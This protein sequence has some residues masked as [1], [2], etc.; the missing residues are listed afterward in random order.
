[1]KKDIEKIT[2]WLKDYSNDVGSKGYVIGLSGGV[3]STAACGL[4][5]DAV[6]KEN[7]LGIMLPFSTDNWLRSPSGDDLK[8]GIRVAEHYGIKYYV[9]PISYGEIII[10]N[11]KQLFDN[12]F[13]NLYHN[14]IKNND[15]CKGNIQARLRM[16]ALRMFAE[17]MNYLVL[18]TTNKSED[19][20]GYFKKGGDGGSGV[21]VEPMSDFYKSEIIKMVEYYGLP[22]DLV[23]R[24]PSAGL[25]K[26]QTDEGEL[27]FTYVDFEKYWKWKENK[28]GDCPVSDEISKEIER[29][30][31]I[32]EHKRSVPSKYNRHDI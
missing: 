23:N 5:V 26:G 28:D 7:V 14:K 27:G 20:L 21:D 6:G 32:T 8:D 22:E 19:M 15:L 16:I 3:D 9:Y 25:W 29:R 24:T 10:P 18:G 11:M 17:A 1:M 31:K 12:D 2:K 30:Y 13:H 4:A